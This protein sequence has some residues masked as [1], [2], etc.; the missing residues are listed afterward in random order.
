MTTVN[1]CPVQGNG[2]LAGLGHLLRRGAVR[3]AR[4]QRWRGGEPLAVGEDEIIG[5]LALLDRSP[6]AARAWHGAICIVQACWS[7]SL[8]PDGSG[9]KVIAAQAGGSLSRRL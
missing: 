3:R 7:P 9:R 2:R 8:M 4:R 1:R 5:R 6:H